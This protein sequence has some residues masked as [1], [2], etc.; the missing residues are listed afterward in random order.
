MAITIP[1]PPPPPPATVARFTAD[2][3]P[4][5]AQVIYETKFYAWL[6]AALA[7]LAA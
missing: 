4:T 7:A 1:E 5:E 2:G 6:K 3:R